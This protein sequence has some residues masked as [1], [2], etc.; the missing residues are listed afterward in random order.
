[1]NS[2]PHLFKQATIWVMQ[3]LVDGLLVEDFFGDISAQLY[4]L[5]QWEDLTQATPQLAS[6]TLFANLDT[7]AKI[8]KLN[9]PNENIQ[10]IMALTPGLTQKWQ[11]VNH[12][13]VYAID[14]SESDTPNQIMLLDPVMFMQYVAEKYYADKPKA[15]RKFLDLLQENIQQLEWSQN[16]QINHQK[17]FTKSPAEFFQCMEQWASL[18]DRPYHPLAKAKTGLNQQDYCQYMAEFS[19]K[20]PLYWIAVHTDYLMIGS[21]IE[22]ISKQ[23]PL[24]YFLTPQ[25]QVKLKA[26]LEQLHISETHIALPV[27]PWQFERVIQQFLPEAFTQQQC[28]ALK[29][30]SSPFNATS[31][32]RS[33]APDSESPF[34]LKLPMD[35]YSLCSARYLPAIKMI[36]GQKSQQLLQQATAKDPQ[37]KEKLWLCDEAI[38]WAYLPENIDDYHP[39]NEILYAQAPRHLSAMLRHYPNELLENTQ[40]KLIPMATLGTV[41]PNH[42]HHFFDDWMQYRQLPPNQTSVRR[43][44]KELC[45]CFYE[46]NLRLFQLGMV[47]EMHGQNAVF[48]WKDGQAQGILMRDHDALRVCVPLLEQNGL[49]DPEYSIKKG[50]PNTLYN[51]QPEDLFFFFQT[52]GIQ[53][54]LRAIIE[55][56]AQVYDIPASLLWQDM[57]SSINHVVTK[58]DLDYST[59]ILLNQLLFKAEYWPFKMLLTPMF[60]HEDDDPGSMPFGKGRIPNPFLQCHKFL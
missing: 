20:I 4:G 9:I 11:K 51:Q 26:E 19:E 6:P 1:V 52:L 32:L 22:N 35:I 57:G 14:A 46:V 60:E 56:L 13:P 31:S 55:T 53:V 40:F 18:R 48:V 5:E 45:D 27:H 59:Q 3:D 8:W 2:H 24:H 21:G 33:L 7:Q 29:F 41:I 38:W 17:L 47:G 37:L 23:H 34:Y 58:I 54:N 44:F 49:S 43:L 50:Y 28:V 39:D 30:Q 12:S 36:N 25:E 15:I 16:H 10:I 42:S